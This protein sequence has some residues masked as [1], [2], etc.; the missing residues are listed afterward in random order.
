MEASD[1]FYFYALLLP[2]IFTSIVITGRGGK[3]K[4]LFKTIFIN[5]IIV[6]ASNTSQVRVL[7]AFALYARKTR[8]DSV[9][10]AIKD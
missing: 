3:E 10:G 5:K 8:T 4:S 1:I 7:K 6:M 2:V 9:G